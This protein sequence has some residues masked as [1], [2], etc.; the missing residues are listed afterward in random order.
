MWSPAGAHSSTC[1]GLII[2]SH[3]FAPSGERTSF[4][5][6]KKKQRK[7]S[8]SG[9]TNFLTEIQPHLPCWI[10]WTWPHEHPSRDKWMKPDSLLNL[11][12]SSAES[13]S[14]FFFKR[15]LLSACG[16]S[17]LRKFSSPPPGSD[18]KHSTGLG[19]KSK[20]GSRYIYIYIFFNIYLCKSPRK[21]QEV[22]QSSM[23]IGGD[24]DRL[25]PIIF[26]FCLSL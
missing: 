10:M 11:E 2:L 13:Q 21:H 3:G 7:A 9:L 18:T 15:S 12:L 22:W 26:V 1:R 8:C 5:E 4:P 24:N 17:F 6:I 19:W 25:Q 16:E 23:Y 14:F 20:L